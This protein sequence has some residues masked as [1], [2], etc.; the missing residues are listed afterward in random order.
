M[1]SANLTTPGKV[2][3]PSNRKKLNDNYVL[4][5]DNTLMSVD[6]SNQNY[7]ETKTRQP[8]VKN[9]ALNSIERMIQQMFDNQSGTP[10]RNNIQSAFKAR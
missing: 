5:F 10:I 2:P 4:A 7:S 1:G 6:R 3:S 9:R 8:Q